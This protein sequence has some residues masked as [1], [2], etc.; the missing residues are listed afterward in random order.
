MNMV[1]FG[2]SDGSKKLTGTKAKI[3]MSSSENESLTF[4]ITGKQPDVLKAMRM[5]LVDS[6]TLAHTLN[7][8]KEHH[9]FLL[10]KGSS[11]LQDIEQMT[12][13]KIIIPKAQ[14]AANDCITIVGAKEDIEK[15][16][17]EI[18]KISVEQSKQAVEKLDVPKIYHPFI[19]GAGNCNIQ[20]GGRLQHYLD[21]LIILIKILKIIRMIIVVV[22]V[23]RHITNLYKSSS[24]VFYNL[25]LHQHIVLPLNNITLSSCSI[26]CW[27]RPC[28]PSM[29][30]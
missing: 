8:P 30:G 2:V 13:T 19:Q 21:Y 15:A 6:Q 29:P 27:C 25:P 24:L 18:Q 14:D 9:G 11:K 26:P 20:V 3:E 16:V 5:I 10:G 1:G 28:W 7:I 17:F 12:A 4:P 22:L 23:I